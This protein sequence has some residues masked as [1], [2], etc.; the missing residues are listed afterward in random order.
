M[1]SGPRT[2][3]TAL[4]RSWGSR[5]DTAVADEPLYAVYLAATG[6]PHPGRAAIL[7]SQPTDWRAVARALTGPVPGGRAI[8]YQKH[9][10]H[11]LLPH[12]GRTWLDGLTHAFLLREPAALLASLARV[13]PDATVADTGLPQQA[14]LFE[15]TA[16]RLGH[17]PPVV[18]ADD[19]RRDPAATLAALCAALG[20]P[21]LPAMLAWAP[22]PRPTDGVWAP[23]WYAS[24]HASTGFDPLADDRPAP[25]V[26]DALR[27]VLDACRPLYNRLASHR[28]TP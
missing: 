18:D 22:G 9:M 2:L 15:R 28:L 10:A 3:S 25:D 12:V 26:P 20:V 17:A 7:A 16:D 11:H 1:W 6:L 8:H 24:V 5:A 23:H 27:S 19:V 4:M 14:E 13:T 21:F